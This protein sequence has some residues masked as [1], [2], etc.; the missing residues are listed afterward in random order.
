MSATQTNNPIEEAAG[1]LALLSDSSCT[2]EDRRA[3]AHWL[4]RS[5]VNVEEFLTLSTL[6]RRLEMSPA[7]PSLD[8]QALIAEARQGEVKVIAL[9]VP[10]KEER[11]VRSQQRRFPWRFAIAAGIVAA[12]ASAIFG[13]N[14][15][16]WFAG[17]T[18]TTSRG[19]LRSITLDDGS[20]VQLDAQSSL[21]THFTAG[22]RNI[23]LQRGAAVF[24]VAKDAAR[25]FKVSTGFADIVAVGTSFNVSAHQERTVVTVL[26]GR[27]A[28][29]ESFGDSLSS[30]ELDP[31]QQVVVEPHKPVVRSTNIDPVKVTAWTSRRLYFDEMPLVQ[32]VQEFSRYSA[33]RIHI[34]DPLLANKPISG[35]FDATDPSSLIEFL[36]RYTDASIETTA[37]GWTVKEK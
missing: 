6:T 22:A 25:P 33:Q 7:W 2:E 1:W 28:V 27:V 20:I 17:S 4:K 14:S 19:E 21:R 24:K 13:L 18:Y 35:T 12:L 23:T 3:F 31:G 30:I 11:T 15:V 32:A 36:K 5:N 29:S 16:A 10:A 37:E 26:E 34:D 9:A 8:I